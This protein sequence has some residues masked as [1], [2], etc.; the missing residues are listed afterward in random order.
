[1]ALQ[2]YVS[3]GILALSLLDLGWI[4]WGFLCSVF[5]FLVRL[6]GL[7]TLIFPVSSIDHNVYTGRDY[8]R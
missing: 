5:V 2:W 3:Q 7:L 4:N 1:M 6:Y 8:L